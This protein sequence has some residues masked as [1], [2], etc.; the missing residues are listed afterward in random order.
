MNTL[1]MMSAKAKSTTHPTQTEKG[2]STNIDKMY[3]TADGFGVKSVP[4]NLA[5]EKE[6]ET[7]MV[8]VISVVVSNKMN[9]DE[10]EQIKK[11]EEN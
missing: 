3:E 9:Q 10:T 4:K 6:N 11:S 7:S 2:S 5:V 8:P 1:P